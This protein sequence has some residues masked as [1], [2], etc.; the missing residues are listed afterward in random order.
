MQKIAVVWFKRDLRLTDHSPLSLALKSGVPVVLLYSFE[1]RLLSDEHYSARHWRFVQQ[2]LT[3]MNHKLSP[4]SARMACSDLGII[5]ALSALLNEFE[6]AGLYSHEETGLMVTF[7]IDKQVATWC[8]ENHVTWHQ[9]PEGAVI[10]GSENRDG[11]DKHWQQTMKATIEHVDL[12]VA[13]F[14]S[15]DSEMLNQPLD[16]D[17]RADMQRGGESEAWKV[18][19]SFFAERGKNYHKSISSP[20]LSQHSCSRLSPYLAWGNLSLRQVY[21]MLLKNWQQPGWRAPLRALSSRLHWHCHFVQKFESEC[22]MEFQPINA[23]YEHFPWCKDQK[24]LNAWKSGHTGYPLVD[25]CMRCLIHTGYINFRMR[26]MLVSFLCHHLLQD[27]RDGVTHLAKLFLDFEPGI[28]YPQ[29]QMQ[30][31]VTGINTV[32][33]YNPVKQSQEQDPNGDFI[34][35]WIPELSEIPNELIHTPWEITPLEEV[36]YDFALGKSYPQPVVDLNESGKRARDLFWHWRKRSDVRK[37]K[38]R[39]L[40]RHIRQERADEN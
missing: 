32:R 37:E 15:L 20:S 2:S 3:D 12:D 18:L 1:P 26:A 11:W 4:Y 8:R 25:A 38:M 29:F 5:D 36:M 30:A 40:H 23:G 9:S 6:I 7:D 10:R 16:C 27:W 17:D 22:Q 39:I 35:Q 28:H 14:A 31:S 24:L 19:D 13:S 34:R 33:I 21:Q